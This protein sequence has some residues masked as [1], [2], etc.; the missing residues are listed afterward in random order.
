MFQ[1]FYLDVAKVD[2]SCCICC[3]DNI[4]ML[5]AYVSKC[6][7]CFKCMFQVFHLDVTYV[8][9]A[10][11]ACFKRIFQVF[12]MFHIY[13]ASVS[14][15]YCICCYTYTRMFQ[16]F[17]LFQTHVANVLSGCFK[18][19][20][21]CYM[22]RWLVDSGR[23]LLLLGRNCGSTHVNF[24]RAGVGW[25]WGCGRWRWARCEVEYWGRDAKA[26][27]PVLSRMQDA[28]VGAASGRDIPSKCPDARP[29]VLNNVNI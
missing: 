5:Q 16:A 20:S 23:L 4:R 22:R 15:G 24:P 12:H 1:V 3:N 27:F 6:F 2:L 19:R 29:P 7:R 18:N 9:M 13:I 28:G 17:C 11:P 25:A 14:S 26:V 8:A 21:G 10:L